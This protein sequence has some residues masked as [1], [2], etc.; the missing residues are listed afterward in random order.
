MHG[1]KTIRAAN[2]YLNSLHN[3]SDLSFFLRQKIPQSKTSSLS[4][5]LI[6]CRIHFLILARRCKV[7][8]V[9]L[10]NQKLGIDQFCKLN[11]RPRCDYV[12]KLR[13]DHKH[14]RLD[15]SCGLLQRAT[16]WF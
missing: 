2:R 4:Q 6:N 8:T 16:E 12:I 14:F 5:E 7:S 3:L 15:T 9:S 13:R 11:C 1:S 10:K